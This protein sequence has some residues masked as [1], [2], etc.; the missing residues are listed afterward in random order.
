L[1]LPLFGEIVLL[2]PNFEFLSF[3]YNFLLLKFG[4]SGS[5]MVYLKL[6]NP[7]VPLASS[8]EFSSLITGYYNSLYNSLGFLGS[9]II[10]ISPLTIIFLSILSIIY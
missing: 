6:N 3:L 2:N 4:G 1:F 9:Y 7:D 5:H 8:I 10:M